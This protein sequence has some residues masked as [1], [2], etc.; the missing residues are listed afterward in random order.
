[1]QPSPH[2]KVWEKIEEGPSPGGAAHAFS[3]YGICIKMRLTTGRNVSSMRKIREYTKLIVP[4][5]SNLV[6][7]AGAS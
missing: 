5:S 7:N 4:F 6:K 3:G 2:R 1:M